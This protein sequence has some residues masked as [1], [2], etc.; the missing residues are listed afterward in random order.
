M[1]M[2]APAR[3]A[4]TVALVRPSAEGLEVFLVRRHDNVAFMGG[5]HVFPGG[6]VDA[7]D[8]LG[9]YP[10]IW[11]GD[12]DPRMRDRTTADAVAF[13]VAAVRELFEEAGI[14]LARPALDLSK[15]DTRAA[16]VAINGGAT[17]RFNAYREAL[18]DGSLTLRDMMERERLR[19]AVDALVLFAHWVTPV[20]ET[21]RFDT[22]FF[23]AIAP[24]SQAAAHDDRETT[25]GV[26]IRPADALERCLRGE[27]ALP[28]PTWTTL[29][30]LSRA[31][32]VE[33]AWRWA[34]A[35]RVVCVQPCFYEDADGT[36]LVMLPGD[37]MCPGVEGFEAE[38]KRFVLEHGRW[39][40]V[41]DG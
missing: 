22:Y 4:S 27:L 12:A 3:P 8:Y 5:A 38:E 20:V 35:Q 39:R 6:R 24:D 19:I 9:D 1:L 10:G 18:L 37:P 14:L 15:D 28:P 34:K 32:T 40:P 17:D 26:W 2:S 13:H 23:L 41:S 30:A 25:H 33:D 21:R 11:N 31:G 7:S 16:I 36:R 29:R